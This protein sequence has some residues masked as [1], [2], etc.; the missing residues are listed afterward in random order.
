MLWKVFGLAP[1]HAADLAESV[2]SASASESSAVSEQAADSSYNAQ[3]NAIDTQAFSGTILPETEDAGSAYVDETLFIG[4][5]NSYRYMSYGFTSLD[6][7]I[8][9]IGMGAGQIT[10]LGCVKFKG[11]SSYLTIPKAVAIMQPKRVVF[12]FG[13]NNLTGSVSSYIDTY[14][15]AIQSVYDAYPY[16][17]VIVNAIPPV[18]KNRDY[19]SVTM[20]NV[21]KFN[22]ALAEMCEAQGWKFLNSSE[23]LKDSATGFAKTNYTVA[24]GLHLSKNGCA[25]LFD[26][27]RTHAC[28]TEDRRPKPLSTVPARA[29][30]PPDLITSDPLKTGKQSTTAKKVEITFTATEGGSIEGSTEQSVSAGGTCSAVKAVP[31]SGYVFAG[32]SCSTGSIANT[33]NPD[34]TF[35]VPSD[36]ASFGGIFVTASFTPVASY[37]VTFTVSNPA[38]ASLGADNLTTVNVTVA[39]GGSAGTYITLNP[40]YTFTATGAEINGNKL[41]VSNVT[42]NVTVMIKITGTATATPTATDTPSATATPAPTPGPAQSQTQPTQT[43]ETTPTAAPATAVPAATEVPTEAPAGSQPGPAA[44]QTTGG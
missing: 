6:N 34:L 12:G 42:Q 19:P 41:T 39:S 33:E 5:S 11:K 26:Y 35:H 27:I 22:A 38:G 9:V 24:D 18:D 4:D 21:D 44:S 23:A 14:E 17:D 15:K 1:V 32:W 13:T 28:Q 37:T 36:S 31:A 20:Q 16:F 40:G 8:A 25:A 10:S 43:P 30:T 7:D 3:A 29:E 2:S